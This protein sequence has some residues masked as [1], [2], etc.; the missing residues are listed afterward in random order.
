M[1]V[2]PAETPVTKPVSEPIVATATLV[3]A[4]VPPA[5][6]SVSVM[7]DATH[8]GETPPIAAG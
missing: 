1:I 3:L 8:T 2:V 5:V 6:A 4:H 7:V